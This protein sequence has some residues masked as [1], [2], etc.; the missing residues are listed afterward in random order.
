MLDDVHAPATPDE[1]ATIIDGGDPDDRGRT[2]IDDVVVT[3]IVGIAAR[4]VSGVHALGGGGA[5]F[6]GAVRDRIPG[7]GVDVQQGVTVEVGQYQAAADV[8]IV[9]EFGVAIH[10]LADA[11]RDNVIVSVERM[12]GLEVT[13]VNV[14]VHDVHLPQDDDED[15]DHDD[16]RP[17]RVR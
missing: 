11:I 16:P 8:S 1:P 13:E 3:K 10:E 17:T 5:R 2:I 15:G 9:A 6:V 4:E 7:A 14:T 12:T